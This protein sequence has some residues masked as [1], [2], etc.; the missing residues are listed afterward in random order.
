MEAKL[1]YALIYDNHEKALED[2][3]QMPIF[4]VFIPAFKNINYIP[5]DILVKRCSMWLLEAQIYCVISNEL[6]IDLTD[7]Y[8]YAHNSSLYIDLFTAQK[9]LQICS[10]VQTEL[11][12]EKNKGKTVMLPHGEMGQLLSPF[13]KPIRELYMDQPIIW[14]NPFNVRSCLIPHYQSLRLANISSSLI[15]N[16]FNSKATFIDIGTGSGIF[17]IKM[18]IDNPNSNGILSDISMEALETAKSNITT[19]GLQNCNTLQS[20]VLTSCKRKNLDVV[21]SNPPFLTREHL[22]KN[23]RFLNDYS[24]LIRT[25]DELAIEPSEAIYYGSTPLYK[26]I[27]REAAPRF[28]ERFLIILECDGSIEQQNDIKC[29]AL[30]LFDNP[31]ILIQ[32]RYIF[33]S[34]GMDKDDMIQIIESSSEIPI[35]N[36]EPEHTTK[37]NIKKITTK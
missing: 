8:S 10:L 36:P 32:N 13:E 15:S 26:R 22:N 5:I 25:I 23:Q 20:D 37:H 11:E 1:D 31:N 6:K 18:A 27:L 3:K 21:I 7:L 14:G 12:Y 33:I 4:P 35:I 28:K 16:I 29:E 30:T 19:F 9:I 17:G 2:I 34:N 24:G